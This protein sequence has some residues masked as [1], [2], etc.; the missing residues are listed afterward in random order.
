MTTTQTAMS[1]FDVMKARGSVR[2]YEKGVEI[3]REELNEILE[4]A[5]KAPSSWNLQH[6]RFIVITSQERKERLLPIAFNQQQVVDASA[7][8]VVLGDLEA[9]KTAKDVYGP[10]LEAG[11]MSQEVFDT[12]M[13]QIEGAYQNKQWARDEAFLN[14][15]FAAMQ[16]M[17]A[18]KAKGYDTCPMGGFDRAALVKELNIPE[19]FVPV[20]LLSLGKAAAPARPTSRLPLEKVVVEETF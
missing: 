3:P 14:A 7:V 12:L 17:L 6:W 1:A 13:S 10:A 9:N 20:M 15:G 19:R 4:L 5:T 8:I 18:A 16:L 2:K 11:H